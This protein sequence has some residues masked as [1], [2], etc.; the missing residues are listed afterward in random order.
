MLNYI[1]TNYIDLDESLFHFT[2]FA[3]YCTV[4]DS[5]IKIKDFLPYKI[6]KNLMNKMIDNFLQIMERRRYMRENISDIA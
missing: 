4:K 3:E 6:K 5:D 1:N 2:N